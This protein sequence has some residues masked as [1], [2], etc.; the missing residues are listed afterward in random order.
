MRLHFPA[1]K[2]PKK[3]PQPVPAEALEKLLNEA[4]DALWRAYLLCGWWAGLRLSEARH[5]QWDSSDSLPWLD[6]EGN[7]IVLPAVFTRSAEDQ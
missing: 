4:P 5:L 2:V 3:K 1:I 6:F 7:R